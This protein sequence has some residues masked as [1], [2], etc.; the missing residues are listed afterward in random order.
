[1]KVLIDKIKIKYSWSRID[2]SVEDAHDLL[3]KFIA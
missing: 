3:D 2:D 1:M